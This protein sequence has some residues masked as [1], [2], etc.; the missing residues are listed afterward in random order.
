MEAWQVALKEAITSAKEL[1][2]FLEHSPQEPFLGEK[3]YPVFIPKNLAHKIKT[4]GPGSAL[5]KQFVPQAQELQGVAGLLDPIGDHLKYAAPQLIHRYFNRALFLPTDRC[6]VICRYC[7][8]KNELLHQDPLF[9]PRWEETA[10]YLQE[11]PQIEEIIFTGGDPLFLSDEKL[12][13]FLEKFSDINHIRYIRFHTRA[14]IVL[15]ERVTSSFLQML[16]DFKKK[17]AEITVV[18]HCNHP[19]EL[20]GIEPTLKKISNQ[21]LT[22]SQSVLLKG[23]NDCPQTLRTFYQ[24]LQRLNIRPYYLHHPDQVRGAMHYT[25]TLAQGQKIY[26]ELRQLLS[27]WMLPQYVLDDPQALGKTAISHSNVPE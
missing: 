8:R 10:H 17:Y 26:G 14:P 16:E 5:W 2:T 9:T 15:P 20:K 1:F 24:K 6:P 11:N 12:R 3:R 7:F 19:D 23:V 27:G 4:H 21:V 13:G 22:L 18:L 25:L